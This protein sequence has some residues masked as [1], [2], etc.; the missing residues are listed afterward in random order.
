MNICLLTRYFDF[1]GTGVTRIALEVANRLQQRG[2]NIHR[3]STNGKNL[4]SYFL[5][6]AITIPLVMPR[7]RIDAYHAL[8]TLEAMW[9]P[10]DRSVATFLDLFTTTN[11]ERA[12]A[13]MGYDKWK[14]AVGK[15]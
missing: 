2:H 8:A 11:P 5:Y 15:G 7:R 12:G 1:R 10:K 13:G 6:T 14:L 9:L 3:I 4:Y